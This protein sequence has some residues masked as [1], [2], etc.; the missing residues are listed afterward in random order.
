MAGSSWRV[1]KKENEHPIFPR[2]VVLTRVQLKLYHSSSGKLFPYVD[3]LRDKLWE[4]QSADA[5]IRELKKVSCKV[6]L[7]AAL[8]G[9][10]AP[11]CSALCTSSIPPSLSDLSSSASSLL[12]ARFLSP[13]LSSWKEF[14]FHQPSLCQLENLSTAVT[15]FSL[16]GVFFHLTCLSWV[17]HCIGTIPL[18]VVQFDRTGLYKQCELGNNNINKKLWM[19]KHMWWW[20]NLTAESIGHIYWEK[21]ADH[22]RVCK[23]AHICLSVA[24]YSVALSIS[25]RPCSFSPWSVDPANF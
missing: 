3:F 21:A 10:A 13:L 18:C 8:G 9:F 6:Q 24:A 12:K 19:S 14:L 1:F 4:T 15:L 7:F 16:L 25:G 20:R 2:V 17:Y 22:R 23:W 5:K 11:P